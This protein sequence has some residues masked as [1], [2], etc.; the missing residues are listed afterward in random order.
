MLYRSLAAAEALCLRR[1]HNIA[2]QLEAAQ[3]D[4]AANP[5]NDPT[6][7]DGRSDTRGDGAD[8]DS[9]VPS[10]EFSKHLASCARRIF[11]VP[12]FQPALASGC[13]DPHGLHL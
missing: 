9:I 4:V 2:V 11:D 5:N 10:H 3:F 12:S 6:L 13:A 7:I 1:V 8:N